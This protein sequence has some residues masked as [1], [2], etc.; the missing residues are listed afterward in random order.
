MAAGAR[1]IL[2]AND[3]LTVCMVNPFFFK[4]RNSTYNNGPELLW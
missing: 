2:L 4:G 1:Y 3:I